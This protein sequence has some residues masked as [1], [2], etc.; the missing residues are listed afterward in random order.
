MVQ[1]APAPKR[2]RKCADVFGR[3]VERF[4][5][6]YLHR[7]P[8]ENPGARDNDIQQLIDPNCGPV[9]SPSVNSSIVPCARVPT[10]VPYSVTQ[11]G[12]RLI[13]PGPAYVQQGGDADQRLTNKTR[14]QATRWQAT[15]D[16]LFVPTNSLQTKYQRLEFIRFCARK[17]LQREH[18][19]LRMSR[20]SPDNATRSPSLRWRRGVLSDHAT[21]RPE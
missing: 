7:H 8:P 19:R 17:R 4:E 15:A 10:Q 9:A 13:E 20:C 16:L 11:L 21:S 6:T 14:S 3:F 2:A 18:A 5:Q 1:H 12:V